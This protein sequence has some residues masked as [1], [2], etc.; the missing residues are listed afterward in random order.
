LRQLE[1]DVTSDVLIVGHREDAVARRLEAA[2]AARGHNAAWLDGPAAARLFTIRVIAVG[3]QVAP[4]MPMFVRPVPWWDTDAQAS[5]DARFLRNECYAA[6]WAAAALCRRSVI[7]RPTPDG[8][9]YR[10]TAGSLGTDAAGLGEIHASGPE[11]VAEDDGAFWGENTEYRV[12]ALAMLPSGV[13]VRA[14]RVDLGAGYE[15]VTV[16]GAQAFPATTDPRSA[17][18]DLAARSIGLARRFRVH[19]A[20]VTWAVTDDTAEAVRLN[21]NPDESELRYRWA[22]VLDALCRDLLA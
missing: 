22:D 19:F 9:V 18:H 5:P 11:Q 15:I 2:L 20:T 12:G 17:A 14:R 4:D 21:P 8:P 10:L 13:P 7:N 3:N 6:F 1:L 16:V